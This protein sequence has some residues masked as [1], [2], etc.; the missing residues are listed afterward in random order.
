MLGRVHDDERF[1]QG[2]GQL[3]LGHTYGQG[4][5]QQRWAGKKGVEHG[6]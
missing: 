4:C 3:D 5:T 2:G 1:A 6:L